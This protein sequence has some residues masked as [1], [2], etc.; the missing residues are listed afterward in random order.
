MDVVLRHVHWSE[1]TAI[2]GEVSIGWT[3]G[4]HS[5]L[6]KSFPSDWLR[7]RVGE[8][9]DFE[10]KRR[11][12]LVSNM[13][14]EAMGDIGLQW[15]LQQSMTVPFD[16][17][18]ESK[19]PKSAC[20]TIRNSERMFAAS[21][22]IPLRDLVQLL[23][24]KVGTEKAVRRNVTLKDLDGK[25]TVAT[26]QLVVRAKV[27]KKQSAKA[28]WIHEA[29]G[30]PEVL[31]TPHQDDLDLGHTGGVDYDKALETILS[32]ESND[33]TDSESDLDSLKYGS[34]E[35]LNM[36]NEARR[37][38]RSMSI[39]QARLCEPLSPV[40]ETRISEHTSDKQVSSPLAIELELHEADLQ[41]A[42]YNHS[43]VSSES[44][45]VEPPVDWH[46]EVAVQESHM[47]PIGENTE[48]WNLPPRIESKKDKVPL[49]Q[50]Q[51]RRLADVTAIFGRVRRRS[52]L[53]VPPPSMASEVTASLP[54]NIQSPRS[55]PPSRRSGNSCSVMSVPV[56]LKTS[57]TSASSESSID[58][59]T[60]FTSTSDS[61]DMTRMSSH[62]LAEQVES[63][64]EATEVDQVVQT[65]TDRVGVNT[66]SVQT[67]EPWGIAPDIAESVDSDFVPKHEPKQVRF[68]EDSGR[69]TQGLLSHA[70]IGEPHVS[71]KPRRL[72]ILEEAP[73]SHW[74]PRSKRRMSN[75]CPSTFERLKALRRWRKGSPV[76]VEQL[77]PKTL[78]P[79]P[80]KK[81]AVESL[82]RPDLK[83]LLD[84]LDNVE[85]SSECELT[86]PRFRKMSE[87]D[88]VDTYAVRR[89]N[90]HLC[91]PLMQK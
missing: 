81:Q 41:V 4:R 37:A 5:L 68:L 77:M 88:F 62:D 33:S 57:P 53:R 17:K 54:T 87:S 16:R 12:S 90:E 11:L 76:G 27:L 72:P 30:P 59:S 66:I 44:Q 20:I 70:Q 6:S 25:D 39:S 24:P 50:P 29:S 23:G 22:L 46:S 3:R 7:S 9:D 45:K 47:S 91:V 40:S 34:F 2:E 15:H 13:S 8:T 49:A 82:L 52:D 18:L 26:A 28:R 64:L 86:I 74:K 58:V 43:E 65:Q 14:S 36:S 71:V 60:D 56:H 10:D 42:A 61:E 63:L 73:P 84:A 1:S 31:D 35:T 55:Y 78:P 51:P 80:K 83:A 79:K 32:E 85:D 21:E 75:P 19:A 89:R 38:S 67:V 48:S 69:S